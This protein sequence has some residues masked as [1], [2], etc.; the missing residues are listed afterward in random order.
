MCTPCG[1]T[2]FFCSLA[3][4]KFLGNLAPGKAI[5]LI[6]FLLITSVI[7]TVSHFLAEQH[8]LF[9]PILSHGALSDATFPQDLKSAV[10]KMRVTSFSDLSIV[11]SLCA[12]IWGTRTRDIL[13]DSS[14]PLSPSSFQSAAGVSAEE[15]LRQ[16]L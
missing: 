7:P 11:T 8:M 10:V 6:N 13:V 12:A 1:M 4:S 16:S 2:I 14:L 15:W 9:R 5:V 3:T